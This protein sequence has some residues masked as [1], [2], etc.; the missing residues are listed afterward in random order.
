MRRRLE[1]AGVKMLG[2][3][4]ATDDIDR[5]NK[6]IQLRTD[7]VWPVGETRTDSNAIRLLDLVSTKSEYT[8]VP[9]KGSPFDRV[10]DVWAGDSSSVSMAQRFELVILAKSIQRPCPRS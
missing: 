3:M 4:L 6:Q 5:G 8:I 9:T 10:T 7:T 1:D 2:A